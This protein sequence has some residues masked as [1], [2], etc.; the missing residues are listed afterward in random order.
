MK[1]VT[2]TLTKG[3]VPDTDPPAARLLGLQVELSPNRKTEPLWV[4]RRL[5]LLRKWSHYEQDKEQVFF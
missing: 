1:P 4:W 5:Q 2:P 3:E